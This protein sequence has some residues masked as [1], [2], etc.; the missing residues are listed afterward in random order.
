LD[1]I[2]ISLNGHNQGVWSVRFSPDGTLLA[3]GS[4][5]KTV[6]L[7]DVKTG[8]EIASLL[9]NDIIMDCSFSPDGLLLAA[10]SNDGTIT[11]WNVKTGTEIKTLKGHRQT[12]WSS[13]F[14]HDG[15]LLAS[16]SEDKSVKIW[17]VRTKRNIMTLEG[18][19]DI[20]M[21]LSFSP[22]G[23]MLSSGSFD[24]TIRIGDLINIQGEDFEVIG[25]LKQSSSFEFNLVLLL[26]EKDLKEILNIGDSV[27]IIAVQLQLG[28]DPTE[29]AQAIEKAPIGNVNDHHERKNGNPLKFLCIKNI[30]T[31]N[32]LA[33]IKRE[34][35]NESI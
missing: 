13:S 34:N 31:I 14:S 24:K 26:P 8:S 32:I 4:I 21:S 27:D 28:A 29:T 5:D 3:S 10:A 19:K 17:D 35:E 11:L 16:G 1:G 33:I 22:D 6:K 18:H 12:I 30:S 9:H 25:R 7:W 20:V 2:T 15:V 23:R